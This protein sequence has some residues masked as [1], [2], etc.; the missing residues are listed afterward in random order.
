MDC[1][2]YSNC[3]LPRGRNENLKEYGI[4]KHNI[5]HPFNIFMYTTIKPDGT[6]LVEEPISKAG[7]KIKLLVEMDTIIGIAS[8][9]VSKSRCNGGKCTSL[10]V[11]IEGQEM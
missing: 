2:V 5:I 3:Y 8:C 7:D 9:S 10:K 11:I 1:F 4:S 6:I